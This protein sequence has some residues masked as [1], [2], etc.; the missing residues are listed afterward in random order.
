[1]KQTILEMHNSLEE[2]CYIAF[3]S[4]NEDYDFGVRKSDKLKFVDENRLV[5][6]R[7]SGRTTI[8][9]LNLIIGICIRQELF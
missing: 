9:N 5:I 7:K 6:H 3:V 1:M 8:I 4:A 2:D